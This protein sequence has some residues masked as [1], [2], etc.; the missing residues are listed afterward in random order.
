M[1]NLG[2][3]LHRMSAWFAIAGGVVLAAMV[4]LVVISILGRDVLQPGPGGL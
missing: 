2:E 3:Q 1:K 4:T